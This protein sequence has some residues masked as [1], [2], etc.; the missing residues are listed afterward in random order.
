MFL[1]ISVTFTLNARVVYLVCRMPTPSGLPGQSR[2]L[3]VSR[4]A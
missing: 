2:A 3:C 4:F 1:Y